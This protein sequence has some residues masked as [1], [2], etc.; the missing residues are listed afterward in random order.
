MPASALK[1]YIAHNIL[2]LIYLYDLLKNNKKSIDN[3]YF[4]DYYYLNNNIIKE[5]DMIITVNKKIQLR[6]E[7]YKSLFK[8]YDTFDRVSYV[9]C[10]GVESWLET[11]LE[12]AISLYNNL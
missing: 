7:G 6:R 2:I 12:A 11:S 9:I 10:Y 1:Y 3:N 5:I 4:Y 8:I